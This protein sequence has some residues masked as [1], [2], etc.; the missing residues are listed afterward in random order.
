MRRTGDVGADEQYSLEA[1]SVVAFDL[2]RN[3]TEQPLQHIHALEIVY[4]SCILGLAFL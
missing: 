2:T 4:K 3:I 1:V